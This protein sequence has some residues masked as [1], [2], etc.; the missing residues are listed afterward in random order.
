[1]NLDKL[2][3]AVYFLDLEGPQVSQNRI[4]FIEMF[5]GTTHMVE[6]RGTVLA[7]IQCKNLHIYIFFY[8][9]FGTCPVRRRQ[10]NHTLTLTV[11]SISYAVLEHR[12]PASE[13]VSI[14]REDG[15]ALKCY[16]SC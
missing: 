12:K 2:R 13:K 9:F 8:G 3:N 1:M 10:P 15:L 4:F 7:H 16:S 5:L 11:S 14:H 6:L